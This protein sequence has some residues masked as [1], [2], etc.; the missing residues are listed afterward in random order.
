MLIA[1]FGQSSSQAPQLVHSEA[2]IW[3]AMK[4]SPMSGWHL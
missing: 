2:M 4:F 3:Y 1:E